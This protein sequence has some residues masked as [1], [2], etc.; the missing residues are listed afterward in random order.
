M[1]EA[2][3]IREHLDE[4]RGKLALRGQAINLDQFVLIDGER[5]KA[6]QEWERLRALQKK[7]SDEVSKK[8]REG[9]DAS[10]LIEEMKKVSRDLKGL[11]GI[12]EEKEMAL[13]DFL[14]TV[15]N[16][17][18]ASVPVGKDSSDNVEVRRWGEIPKFDF[19]PKASLGFRGGVRDS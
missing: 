6:I 17:P 14:L 11:D 8:K 16:L 1:L 18:H 15:P 2:K 3:Y 5:R 12:I 4:V 19:E 7:V 13:Q 10:D 9:Q